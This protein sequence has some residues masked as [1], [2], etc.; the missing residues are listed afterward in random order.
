MSA[1]R[2]AAR[3]LLK[4]ETNASIEQHSLRIGGLALHRLNQPA[5]I[6]GAAMAV[7]SV[8]SAL[9]APWIAHQSPL[10]VGNSILA[11]PSSQHLFGTDELGRDVFSRVVYA[12]RPSLVVAFSSALIALLLGGAVGILAGYFGGWFD[13]VSMRILDM[14]LAFPAILFAVAL[15]AALGPSTRNLILTI[16]I[17]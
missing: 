8:F 16:A 17:L 10:A 14:L 2:E 1:Q 5:L 15:V 7:L 13:G 11:A 6:V 3:P 4:A 12:A 9:A